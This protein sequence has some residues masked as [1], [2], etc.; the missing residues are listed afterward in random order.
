MLGAEVVNPKVVLAKAGAVDVE[1]W[2]RAALRFPNGPLF[3]LEAASVGL[4][5]WWTNVQA[6]PMHMHGNGNICCPITGACCGNL[7]LP[8]VLGPTT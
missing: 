3:V 4:V 5:M 6:G 7:Q 8:A 2:L 1:G